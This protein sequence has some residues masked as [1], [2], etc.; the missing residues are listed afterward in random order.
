MSFNEKN[1][2]FICV[3]E[4]HLVILYYNVLCFIYEGPQFYSINYIHW[5]PQ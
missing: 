1:N 5:C 4:E 3:Q 2:N